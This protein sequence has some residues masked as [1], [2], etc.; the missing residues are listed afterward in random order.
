[1]NIVIII[2][3]H[4]P[5]S[6]LRSVVMAASRQD[7]PS[8]AHVRIVVVENGSV[9]AET[10][11]AGTRATYVHIERAN[12]SNARNVGSTTL[13][14]PDILVFLD[15]DAVPHDG[16]LR[17]LVRP[18]MDGESESAAGAVRMRTETDVPPAV[19]ARFVDTDVAIDPAAPFLVGANMAINGSVFRCLGGFDDR[20]GPG[21]NAS[22]GEDVL[23][24]LR[25][26]EAGGQIVWVP[27]AIVD[28]HVPASRLTRR[29][30]LK[31]AAAGGRGDAWVVA[32]HHHSA[33]RF[34]LVRLVRSWLFRVLVTLIPLRGLRLERSMKAATR[35][36]RDLYLA[37][38]RHPMLAGSANISRS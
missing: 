34:A 32:F 17:A 28:H 2:P 20:L 13:G 23:L 14:R 22:G 18:I 19:R 8:D 11:L 12:A 9:G 33:P 29:A 16:W 7:I 30:L 4:K 6:V 36:S 37:R 5:Q 31:R 1:M 27:D 35:L 24:G 25:V 26:V 3:T 15:D 38:L 21:T 10:L